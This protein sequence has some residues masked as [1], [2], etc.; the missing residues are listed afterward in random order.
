MG[1]IRRGVI[2]MASLVQS[3]HDALAGEQ[4]DRDDRDDRQ[5]SLAPS[6]LGCLHGAHGTRTRRNRNPM[7]P[8]ARLSAPRPLVSLSIVVVGPE[9]R[10]GSLASVRVRRPNHGRQF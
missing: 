3:R 7:F 4:A 9:T 5:E 2:G 10:S 8:K 6:V 1:G